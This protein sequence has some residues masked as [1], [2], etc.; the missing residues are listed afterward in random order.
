MSCTPLL[1]VGY[2]TLWPM[3]ECFCHI[4]VGIHRSGGRSAFAY[5]S[6]Q[7]GAERGTTLNVLPVFS[8]KV[9]L[10]STPPWTLCVC[11]SETVVNGDGG[12]PAPC[13]FQRLAWV[14][15]GL[16]GELAQL[17]SQANPTSAQTDAVIPPG[18]PVSSRSRS[19]KAEFRR[20]TT[21][22]LINHRHRRATIN[23]VPTSESFPRFFLFSAMGHPF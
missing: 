9:V 21:I 5:P 14:G 3:G 7:G 13:V 20:H 22:P 15:N 11:G 18:T 10:E 19:L 4:G 23:E 6:A 1:E 12:A 17:V 8:S 16:D 2:V